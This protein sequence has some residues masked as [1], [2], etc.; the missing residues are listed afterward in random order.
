MASR[1]EIAV[2][3]TPGVHLWSP[4]AGL[5][6]AEVIVKG[7]GG[8]GGS[9]M[10]HATTNARRPGPGGGG[11]GVT[12]SRRLSALDL[13]A[14][15]PVT[16]GAG[17]AGGIVPAATDGAWTPGGDGGA[18]LFG[19]FVRA[20]GGF[21]GGRRF[22]TDETS[23]AQG[24]Y[25]GHAVIRGGHGASYA[26]EAQSSVSGIVRLLA[27]GGGGGRGAGYNAAGSAVLWT[28]GGA[29]GPS[30]LGANWRTAWAVTH[31]SGYGGAGAQTGAMGAAG[32]FPAGGGGGGAGG[33]VGTA[34]GKGGDGQ[35]VII[36][37]MR[38]T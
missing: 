38:E 5:Y 14:G 7:A 8:G 17:G 15:V 34:G 24:G 9:G 32:A 4:P 12:L 30:G 26:A 31:V 1:T 33:A 13:E 11:G 2:F 3:S 19:E 22:G 35:V 25:G 16:V 20:E 10:S 23:I 27:A 18:S 6:A 28:N 29:S 36:M 21:G 37:F